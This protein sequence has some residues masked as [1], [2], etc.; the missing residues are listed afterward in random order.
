MPRKKKEPEVIEEQDDVLVDEQ[1]ETEEVEESGDETTELTRRPRKS[2]HVLT[3]DQHAHVKGA[4]A[5]INKIQRRVQRNG[6]ELIRLYF[7]QGYELKDIVHNSEYGDK[8]VARIADA[9]K[10]HKST[11]YKSWAFANAFGFDQKRLE[12][13][14][15]QAKSLG[16]KINFSTWEKKY[17]NQKDPNVVG[18]DEEYK[19]L[20]LNRAERLADAIGEA[21]SVVGS[22][23]EIEGVTAFASE[24]VRDF[25]KA[26]D[27]GDVVQYKNETFLNYISKQP[28]CLTGEPAV[29]HRPYGTVSDILALPLS[30]AIINLAEEAGLDAIEEQYGSLFI[31]WLRVLQGFVDLMTD[32]G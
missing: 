13:E 26:M 21:T 27:R 29:I 25:L 17:L 20:Q 32:E 1:E 8:T 22:D 19:N 31:H 6:E 7:Q 3:D 5:A 12:S 18:G 2:K 16:S 9:T 30:P 14:I 23:E 15:D 11:L 28:C 24:A 4:I 10:E